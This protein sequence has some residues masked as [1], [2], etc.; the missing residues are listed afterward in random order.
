MACLN[1]GL[2]SPSGSSCGLCTVW[3]CSVV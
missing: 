3:Y 1:G 2:R